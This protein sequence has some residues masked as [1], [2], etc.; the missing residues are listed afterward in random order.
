MVE[1]D[2]SVWPAALLVSALLIVGLFWTSSYLA[3][4]VKDNAKTPV[5]VDLTSFTTA[6][7]G[8]KTS[9]DTLKSTSVGTSTSNASNVVI[10]KED[11]EKQSTENK[12]LELALE[13]INSRDFRKSVFELLVD[14]NVTVENYKDITAVKILDKDV[15]NDEVE[16]DIKVYYFVDGDEDETQKARIEE[17]TVTVDDLEFDD[18]FEDAEVDES[19]MDDLVLQTVY[20]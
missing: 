18:N 5:N 13:S 4:V 3:G 15:D 16:F 9:V 20:K 19:Y 1:K 17:F 12:A 7:N 11:F 10:T 2:K 8:V 14:N 6:L